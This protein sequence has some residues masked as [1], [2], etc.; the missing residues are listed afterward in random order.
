MSRKRQQLFLNCRAALYNSARPK[1]SN[2][3]VI[4]YPTESRRR[5]HHADDMGVSKPE[6]LQDFKLWICMVH[7]AL[8]ITWLLLTC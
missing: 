6:T 2:S 5:R 7:V 1:S 3:L 4:D 8:H